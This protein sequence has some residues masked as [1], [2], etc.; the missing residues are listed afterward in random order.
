MALPRLKWP[1]KTSA[2]VAAVIA[3]VLGGYVGSAWV[4]LDFSEVAYPNDEEYFGERQVAFGPR[5]RL[6][7]CHPA[8][9]DIPG[10]ASYDG[11]EWA[12]VVYR[13]ICQ[14]W[15]TRH[16]FAPPGRWR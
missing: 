11:S 3:L 2:R 16:D 15:L 7:L 1:Q 10:G 5:P 4:V 12:L 14:L 8:Y 6:L 9:L 13:P